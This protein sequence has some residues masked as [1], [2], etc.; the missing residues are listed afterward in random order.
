MPYFK[1]FLRPKR[2]NT[3]SHMNSCVLD[4]RRLSKNTLRY[5]LAGTHYESVFLTMYEAK[6]QEYHT[7]R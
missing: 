2:K 6:M 4:A 5:V 3:S 7:L 1:V